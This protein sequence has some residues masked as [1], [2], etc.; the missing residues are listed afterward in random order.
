MLDKGGKEIFEGDL[1]NYRYQLGEHDTELTQG[2]VYF[3]EGI[4]HFDRSM[5]WAMNDVCLISKSLEV[6]GNIFEGE[7]TL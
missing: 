4:F 5:E 2:E 7:Q 1:V 3:E 6:I